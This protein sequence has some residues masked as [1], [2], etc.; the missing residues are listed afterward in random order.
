MPDF[1]RISPIAQRG[2][3]QCALPVTKV[4]GNKSNKNGQILLSDPFLAI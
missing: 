1:Q 3:Q 2:K 4:E